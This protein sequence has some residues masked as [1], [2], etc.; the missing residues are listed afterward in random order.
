M[1]SSD[2]SMKGNRGGGENF[3]SLGYSGP[4]GAAGESL[5][6]QSNRSVAAE[7]VGKPDFSLALLWLQTE[8]IYLFFFFS[9]PGRCSLP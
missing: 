3:S 2:V 4:T 9:R 8:L 1:A 5:K 7:R 6:T